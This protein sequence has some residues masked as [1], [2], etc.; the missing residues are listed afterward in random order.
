MN[1]KP[2]RN[3]KLTEVKL[4]L[5]MPQSLKDRLDKEADQRQISFNAMI[6]QVLIKWLNKPVL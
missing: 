1:R 6:R 5:T 2:Q 4:Q 3:R